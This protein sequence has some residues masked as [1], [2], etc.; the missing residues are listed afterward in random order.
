MS[1][2]K[3]QVYIELMTVDELH[4]IFTTYEMR[5]RLDGPSRKEVEFKA[6]KDINNFEALSKN[7]SKNWD[8]EKSLFIKK[9]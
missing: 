9:R 5:T 7:H 3:E 2:S 6:S 8:D 4:G 1:P